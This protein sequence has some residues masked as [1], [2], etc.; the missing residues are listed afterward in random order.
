MD[1]DEAKAVNEEEL[2]DTSVGAEEN[3]VEY[4]GKVEFNGEDA[5]EEQR[6]MEEPAVDEGNC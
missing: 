2:Q 3:G 4:D 5:T 6:D 1:N